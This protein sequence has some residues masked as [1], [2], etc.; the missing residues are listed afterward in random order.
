MR[1]FFY[2]ILV[3]LA[4]RFGLAPVRVLARGVAAGYFFLFPVRVAASRRFYRD[5]FPG[6]GAFFALCCAWRQFQQFAEVFADRLRLEGFGP[7]VYRCEGLDTLA[8]ARNAGQG[9]VLLMSHLGNWEVA[10]RVLKRHLPGLE[11][12]LFMGAEPGEQIEGLQKASVRTSHIKVVGVGPQTAS[13]LEIVEAVRFLRR[14]GFV[15][16]AGDRVWQAGQSTV[17]VDF[18]GRP[19]ALPRAPFHLAAATGAPLFVFFA[20]RE[21]PGRFLFEARQIPPSAQAPAVR[22]EAAVRRAAQAY[23]DLLAVAVRRHPFQWHHFVPLD[24][25]VPV[26][27]GGDRRPERR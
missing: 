24:C 27:E 5:L 23:A 25:G 18:L 21:A 3:C 15:S 22:R 2:R 1:I 9:A 14:G 13:P 11:L 4:R 12:M 8:D 10:A 7:L 19:A 6:R 17:A 20:L 16:M 26:A